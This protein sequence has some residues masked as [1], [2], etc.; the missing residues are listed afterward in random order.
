MILQLWILIEGG[1][2]C[3]FCK[4]FVTIFPISHFFAIF[5][6][7]SLFVDI[8]LD[9]IV[10]PPQYTIV[11]PVRQIFLRFSSI[12][13]FHSAPHALHCSFENKFLRRKVHARW[14]EMIKAR[15]RS[16]EG[17]A[18]VIFADD[19]TVCLSQCWGL[20]MPNFD[21]R[22]N[23][24][25]STFSRVRT[26]LHKIHQLRQITSFAMYYSTICIQTNFQWFINFHTKFSLIDWIHRKQER[27]EMFPDSPISVTFVIKGIRGLSW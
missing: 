20:M 10:K 2:T 23:L 12:L 18:S 9:Y 19:N 21:N 24:D 25:D 27:L 15:C 7:H 6:V 22:T 4:P 16:Q 11:D 14:N 26:I 5:I 3:T 1:A 13:Y 8:F 17:R